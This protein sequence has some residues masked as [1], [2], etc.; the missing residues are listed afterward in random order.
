MTKKLIRLKGDPK[1]HTEILQRI[2]WRYYCSFWKT[3]TF[4]WAW[5]I[6]CIYYHTASYFEQKLNIMVFSFYIKICRENG[7]FGTS[8]YS[9]EIFSG[10]YTNFTSFIPLTY[11]FVLSLYY[12]FSL[13]VLLIFGFFNVL[14]RIGITNPNLRKFFRNMFTHKIV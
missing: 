10:V 6:C 8:V 9:K 7:K 5:T 3:W 1:I 13:L 11:N 12:P 2:C 14:Y 4:T